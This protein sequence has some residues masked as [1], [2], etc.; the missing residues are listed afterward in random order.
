[1]SRARLALA[2]T[3][4]LVALPAIAHAQVFLASKPHPAFEIG[5]LFV[6]ASVTPELG[7]IQV[8]VTWSVSV[9][10]NRTVADLE[11]DMTLLW[12]G[13]LVHDHKAERDATLVKYVTDHGFKV[14]DGGRVEMFAIDQFGPPGR[15]R[16]PIDGGAVFVSYIR[17]SE[18]LGPS[19]PATLIRIPWDPRVVNRAFLM[20]IS[21]KAKDLIKP[22]SGTWLEHTLWGNRYRL[23]LSFSEVRQRAIFPLYLANRDRVIR[24]SEDPAQMMVDFADN[25]RLKIDEMAPASARRA[26]SETR[27][28]TDTVSVFLDRSEGLIPQTL[29]VQFGYFSGLQSWAPVLIP[30]AIFAAGNVGGVLLRNVAERLGK[31][32]AGRVGFWS[33]R[34]EDRTRETGV[35]LDR[36]TL[37]KIRPGTTTYEQVLELCGRTVEER[38]SPLG[39]PDRRTLVYRGRRI[40]PRRRRVAGLL[41]T[42]THWDVE[43]HEVEI[44]LEH[45]VVRDVQ[46]HVRRS[47]LM[48]PAPAG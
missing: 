38:T 3:L 13:G 24:L 23:T 39:A 14:V 25:E 20:R 17:D 40:V 34:A 2:T 29:A 47:R 32:W 15:R 42:V 28:K 30:L 7:P 37:A 6:R 27:K 33:A 10:A 43:D 8:D 41:A 46:A 48:E 18:T 5:P 11:Q 16:Q 19:A 1:M 35:L 4:L 44:V 22:K 36:D 26:P 12:P 21:M 31:R 45:D 9:P